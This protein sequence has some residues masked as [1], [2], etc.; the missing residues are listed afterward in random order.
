MVGL[1]SAGLSVGCG[2]GPELGSSVG[3]G[4]AGLSVGGNSGPVP[5][6][7]V[8]LGPAGLSVACG[9]AGLSVACGPAGLSVAVGPTGLSLGCGPGPGCSVGSSREG[10]VVGVPWRSRFCGP[11]GSPS[12][13]CSSRRSRSISR[14]SSRS[15]SCSSPDR[16]RAAWTISCCRSCRVVISLWA[17]CRAA[18]P[19]AWLIACT[20]RDSCSLA[21]ATVASSTARPCSR[22]VTISSSRVS[23]RCTASSTRAA[24][25]WVQFRRISSANSLR[26]YRG[27]P[28]RLL[29]AA[30][31]TPKTNPMISTAAI[32]APASLS[33]CVRPNQFS[34]LTVFL[35]RKP[36]ASV[37][38][39]WRPTSSPLGGGGGVSAR[40]DN[41]WAVWTN[42][43]SSPSILS[44]SA[45]RCSDSSNRSASLLLISLFL[46]A[47]QELS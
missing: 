15:G 35:A 10:E 4:P 41:S 8:G 43:A 27:P 42:G 17:A 37:R 26:S 7:S 31:P 40:A 18:C 33:L 25:L 14:K 30:C 46:F 1:G 34:C 32:R 20:A 38:N 16:E 5:G 13:E 47:L 44:P 22:R 6:S 21:L 19:S 36:A 3:L 45:A 23:H 11:L 9:P 2:S 29:A 24:G 39:R 28:G 12:P